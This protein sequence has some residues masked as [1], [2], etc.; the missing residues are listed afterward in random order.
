VQNGTSG[1]APAEA[2]MEMPEPGS[3]I[4]Q[5]PRGLM[6]ALLLARLMP[7]LAWLFV[8]FAGVY[9][10]SLAPDL[11]PGT[12][13]RTD[14]WALVTLSSA[15]TS[16]VL[17]LP[18]AVLIWRRD[19]LSSSPTRWVF[20]GAVLWVLP[21][22][23]WFIVIRFNLPSIHIGE[24]E[25][26]RSNL[27]LARDLLQIA[28]IAAPATIAWGLMGTRSRTVTTWPLLPLVIAVIA[29]L[30]MVGLR[31]PDVFSDEYSPFA[32]SAPQQLSFRGFALLRACYG[33]WP[34]SYG[35]LGWSSLSALRAGDPPD[36]Q[37]RLLSIG[38]AVMAAVALYGVVVGLALDRWPD[39]VS[40]P[41]ASNWT[42]AALEV[43]AIAAVAM[44]MAAFVAGRSEL[45]EASSEAVPEAG[46]APYSTSSRR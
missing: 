43:P 20:L 28:A 18:A 37:W 10:V 24:Y 7:P 39:L 45:A 1:R 41:F 46:S 31:L 34:L 4:E 44:I 27:Q 9:A 32:P 2:D 35:V 5:E 22:V 23:F 26:V 38:A 40:S 42:L 14:F 33:A 19:A 6:R 21:T 17:L 15:L 30:A 8:L 25:T 16:V 13:L 29:T 12:S 11:L 36:R 3:P